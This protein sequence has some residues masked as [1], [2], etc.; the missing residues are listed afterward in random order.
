M[1]NPQPNRDE[2]M[3]PI[4]TVDFGDLRVQQ[5]G[6]IYEGLMEHHFHRDHN[7]LKLVADKAERRETGTYYTP[8]YIV[9]YI[10]EQTIG[11]LL[12]EIERHDRVKKA[13]A[14]GSED[15]SFGREA[16]K[17][18]VLDPAMGSGHFL[19][20]ATTY[21]AEEIAAHPTTKSLG[22][23]SKDEDEIA[24]WRRRVVESCIY[25][26]D[27]N[28]LAVELHYS[29]TLAQYDRRG[30]AA[31]FSRPS[32]LLRKFTNWRAARRSRPRS[33]T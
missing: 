3:L 32:P 29:F 2:P 13:R 12:A 22:E 10:V 9:K 11:P 16:L 30:S 19:V 28:P 33:R 8:D 4:E 14:A 15:N 26:V 17:L 7:T 5:L 24:H 25:G 31:R 20:N 1:F 21:L 18:N 6:S 27:L 23:K